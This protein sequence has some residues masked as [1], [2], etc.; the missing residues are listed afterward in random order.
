MAERQL[1]LF[2][3]TKQVRA[4][5]T[6]TI[7]STNGCV[8]LARNK[9]NG[10]LYVG[11]TI[12]KLSKRQRAHRCDGLHGKV[13]GLGRA[14]AKYG[15]DNFE[16]SV[17]A[18]SNDP[19]ELVRLEV[20]FIAN[21]QTKAPNGYNLTDGGE[22]VVGYTPSAETRKKMSVARKATKQSP[23]TIA[24]AALARIG[25]PVSQETRAKLAKSNRGKKRS[26]ELCAK[27]S[28]IHQ[29]EKR[30]PHSEDHRSK[31]AAALK[32]KKH[33]PER[34]KAIITGRRRAR[35]A[36]KANDNG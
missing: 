27:L 12:C 14:I 2:E 36:R 3:D 16:W 11:K 23:E 28:A 5:N 32:G 34:I 20:E 25:R 8:Y 19:A 26:A 35:D 13:T 24:K 6:L 30:G 31:I 7:L 17:L 22:G 10:K 4:P 1:T 33:S 15:F 18:E 29:G 21:L 9:I